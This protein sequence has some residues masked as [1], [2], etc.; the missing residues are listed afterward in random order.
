VLVIFI[1]IFVSL[2]AVLMLVKIILIVYRIKIGKWPSSLRFLLG[3][4]E[5]WKEALKIIALAL[6][7]A[8]LSWIIAVK[9]FME[10]TN[11]DFRKL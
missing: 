9:S 2:L 6:V 8:F 7:A 4:V 11:L 1:T 3:I 10:H 5:W